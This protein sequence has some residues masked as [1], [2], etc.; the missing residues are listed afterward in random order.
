M[1]VVKVMV[2]V[3]VMI[4]VMVVVMSMV[5]VMVMGMVMGEVMGM[6]MGVVMGMVMVVVMC[7]VMGVVMG[8]VVVVVMGVVVVMIE[9]NGDLQ[10]RQ[11][12]G[13]I[14]L[15]IIKGPVSR[16]HLVRAPDTLTRHLS[17]VI[18]HP[19]HSRTFKHKMF[20]LRMQKENSQFIFQ[21]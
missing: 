6:V 1:V 21:Y 19:P 20:I 2:M 10:A 11:E 8:M 9:D 15:V 16:A 18:C 4:V 12:D 17:P 13:A 14:W 7:M 5:M 3:V